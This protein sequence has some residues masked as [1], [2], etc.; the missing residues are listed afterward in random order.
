[1][2]ISANNVSNRSEISSY[3]HK[4]TKLLLNYLIAPHQ[5]SKKEL[6]EAQTLTTFKPGCSGF[7]TTRKPFSLSCGKRFVIWIKQTQCHVLTGDVADRGK[8]Q[9]DINY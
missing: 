1:L 7:L 5:P 4:E 9:V 8:R 2:V 6:M 3:S